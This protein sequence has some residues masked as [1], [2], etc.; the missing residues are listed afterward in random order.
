MRSRSI[1]AA[2]RRTGSMMFF[3]ARVLASFATR[4]RRECRSQDEPSLRRNFSVVWVSRLRTNRAVGF[5]IFGGE[6]PNKI[7]LSK[8]T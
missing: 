2:N 4:D 7:E 5:E 3:F 1:F 8:S 6:P